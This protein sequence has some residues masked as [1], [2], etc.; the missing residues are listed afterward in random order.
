M[1]RVRAALA[2]VGLDGAN[3]GL[4]LSLGAATAQRG[5][6]LASVLARADAAMYTAKREA[7]AARC[8]ADAA[9]REAEA[10]G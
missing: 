3:A 6:S 7:D 2:G 9:R 5:E 4:A 10:E 8:E 1:G